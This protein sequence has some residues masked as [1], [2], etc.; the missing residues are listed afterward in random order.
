MSSELQKGIVYKLPNEVVIG[1]KRDGGL[2]CTKC[3]VSLLS[4][5][6]QVAR[7]VRKI[8]ANQCPGCQVALTEG[9]K[10]EQFICVQCF[11]WRVPPHILQRLDSQS[12]FDTYGN[13]RSMKEFL[14][15]DVSDEA[16]PIQFYDN[17]SQ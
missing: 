4:D 17:I 1:V 3:K 11:D 13:Q 14:E 9:R 12:V 8:Y 5:G 6:E 10:S 16:C 2:F 7:R 15:R